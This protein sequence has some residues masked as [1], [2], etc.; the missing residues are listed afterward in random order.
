[1]IKLK[2][3]REQQMNLWRQMDED[4]SANMRHGTDKVDESASMIRNVLG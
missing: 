3:T 2:D 1:M 4:K